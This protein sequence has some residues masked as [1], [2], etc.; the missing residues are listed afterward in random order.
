MSTPQQ[1]SPEPQRALVAAL[2]RLLAP[3]VR[4][5]VAN[6]ITH[7]FLGNLLKRVYV[8]VAEREFAIEGRPQTISRLSL[9]T[10]IHRKDV[11]RLREEP[12]EVATVPRTVS[13]GAQLVSRWVGLP[14]FR[15]DDG[16]RPL[17]R[18]AA[19]DGSPSFE[20]LVESVSKDI[21]PR[22]ILDE[23]VRLGVARIDESDRV[24]LNTRAFVP[25][26]GFDEKA[27]YLGRSLSDHIAAAARNLD[28]QEPPLL[29]RTVYYDELSEESVAELADLSRQLGADALDAVNR[30][31]LELQT[32]DA[33]QPGANRRMSFGV[34]FFEERDAASED[35]DE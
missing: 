28:G 31:A 14:E 6:G 5:L 9:L 19:R 16:P 25:A 3:L 21:R 29:E 17:P 12:P 22:A 32:R 2:S 33:E 34:Y 23:W 20:S 30:R 11:K 4:L 10:G 24:R 15:D 7:P 1:A 35:S 8:D 26:R 18:L 27:H 13:L